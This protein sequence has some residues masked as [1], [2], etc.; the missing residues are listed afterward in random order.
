MIQIPTGCH[1]QTQ[2]IRLLSNTGLCNSLYTV[3]PC[4]ALQGT[5]LELDSG[6]DNYIILEY[7]QCRKCCWQRG[8]GALVPLHFCKWANLLFFHPQGM[9]TVKIFKFSKIKN[10]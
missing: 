2:T 8:E 9:T 7:M 6:D 3:N 4:S 1:H 10:I 5:S